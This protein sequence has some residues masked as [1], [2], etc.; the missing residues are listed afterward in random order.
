MSIAIRYQRS[1]YD[2]PVALLAKFAESHA[3]AIKSEKLAH[4]ALNRERAKLN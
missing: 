2:R 4:E 1:A 3:I